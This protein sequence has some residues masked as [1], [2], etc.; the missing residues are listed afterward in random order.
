MSSCVRK[1]ADPKLPEKTYIELKCVMEIGNDKTEA[2]I[3]FTGRNDQGLKHRG[4]NL[5]K[6]N[7]LRMFMF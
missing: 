5:R 2:E 1:M 6:R 3:M 4:Q 7:W